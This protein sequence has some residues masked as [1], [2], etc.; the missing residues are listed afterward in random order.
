MSGLQSNTKL[1]AV[2]NIKLQ[3]GMYS[4]HVVTSSPV[5]SLSGDNL[6][7]PSSKLLTFIITRTVACRPLQAEDD[8]NNIRVYRGIYQKVMTHKMG[9][10]MYLNYISQSGA[11]MHGHLF[12]NID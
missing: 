8:T 12:T 9:G 4:I 10:E 1:L 7:Q 6:T 11:I 2:V 3:E 5:D